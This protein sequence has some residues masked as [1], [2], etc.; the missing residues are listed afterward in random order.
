MNAYAEE[1]NESEQVSTSTKR[2]RKIFD[3]KYKNAH[4]NEV[5]KHQ[6]PHLTE[7]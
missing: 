2:L 4:L 5:I 3:A 7:K 1:I 6:C